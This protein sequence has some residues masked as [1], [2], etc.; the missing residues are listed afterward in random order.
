MCFWNWQKCV[1]V[2][3]S[4]QRAAQSEHPA[5]PGE[6]SGWWCHRSHLLSSEPLSPE[7]PSVPGP[8]EDN[9]RETW[10]TANEDKTQEKGSFSE[11][12]KGMFPL[13]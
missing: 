10:T 2:Y 11:V 5:A 12:Q 6:G 8:P 7:I 3:D 1:C 4:Y 13:L 9:K